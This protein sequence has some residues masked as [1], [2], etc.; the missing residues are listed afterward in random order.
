MI[1]NIVIILAIFASTLFLPSCDTF[2][3]ESEAPSYIQID[4]VSFVSNQSTEGTANQ[5]ISDVW[6]NIEGNRIGAFE[7]PTR[8]PVIAEGKKNVTMYA[9]ILK[10]GIHIFREIYPFFEPIKEEITFKGTEIIK[11]N[12]S[13]K[14]KDNLEFW[15]EDFE[16]PGLKFHTISDVNYLNQIIDS[17]NPINRL[18]HVLLPDTAKAFQFFTKNKFKLSFFPIYMEMEYKCDQDF[19]IGI[20]VEKIDGSYESVRPFSIIKKTDKWNKLYINLAE[21]F[22]LN[23]EA[24]SYEVYFFFSK[25][26]PLP[27]NFYFDNI[28]I[29]TYENN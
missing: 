25:E 20:L 11:T 14:Y 1:R 27:L 7:M 2:E 18:G 9:G 16:D 5:Q 28:K 6:F 21:Q 19:S 23:S 24:I 10:N 4:S 3:G 17:R 13:F 26:N 15:I 8:F 12:P 22:S 29:I